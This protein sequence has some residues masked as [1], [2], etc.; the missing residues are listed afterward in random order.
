MYILH[1]L[2]PWISFE[3]PKLVPLI[4]HID[5]DEGANLTQVCM[6]ESGDKANLDFKW[7]KNSK[8]IWTSKD[9]DK[10]KFEKPKQTEADY[11]LIRI[12]NLTSDDSGNYTCQVSNSHG[13]DKTSSILKVRSK[14]RLI[15]KTQH[16][17]VKWNSY[18]NQQ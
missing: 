10:I 8:E 14:F 7:F 2:I 15:A 9:G 13:I 12:Y 16:Q 17:K 3:E 6:L 5:K 11:Y 18:P 4:N 1:I